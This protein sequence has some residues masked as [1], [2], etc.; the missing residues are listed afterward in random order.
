MESNRELGE[1]KKSN[2]SKQTMGNDCFVSRTLGSVQ[3]SLFTVPKDSI[4]AYSI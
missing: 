2:V 3:R 4:I 1:R